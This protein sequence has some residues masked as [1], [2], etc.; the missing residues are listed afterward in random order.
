MASKKTDLDMFEE[1]VRA[2]SKIQ[3]EL[4]EILKFKRTYEERLKASAFIRV[5]GLLTSAAFSLWRAAFLFS[6]EAGQ[7]EDYLKNV[8]T[9]LTKVIT[10][11]TIGFSDDKNTWSLWHY[12]G[13]ARSSLLEASTILTSGLFKAGITD[14][15]FAVVQAKLSD[16]PLLSASAASQWDYLFD[17]MV[18]VRTTCASQIRALA[19]MKSLY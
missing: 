16:P 12:I 13:V 3:T 7:H 17:V 19:A 4:I 1:M 8:E 11:N 6:H 5:T 2:R 10:D 15:K 14:A 9:F 18:L